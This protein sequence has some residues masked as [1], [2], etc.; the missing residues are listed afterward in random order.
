MGKGS[1]LLKNRRF[2]ITS[3]IIIFIIIF[4]GLSWIAGI[5]SFGSNKTTQ[6]N[7]ISKANGVITSVV[8]NSVYSTSGLA[9]YIGTEAGF[10]YNTNG[11]E[12][13]N[14][15]LTNTR[16]T[17]IEI[18]GISPNLK[19]FN[20]IV[21]NQNLPVILASGKTI[22]F[23]L[24]INTP[25]IP[26]NGTLMLNYNYVYKQSN[27]I[28]VTSN[29]TINNH[30]AL[31]C[32]KLSLTL[33]SPY[34]SKTG[35]CNWPGGTLNLSWSTGDSVAITINIT[36]NAGYS[37]D[38]SANNSKSF[39]LYCLSNS[40][41]VSLPPGNYSVVFS[42][43]AGGA[44]CS[45]ST[46]Y[47]EFNNNLKVSTNNVTKITSNSTNTNTSLNTQNECYLTGGNSSYY[48]T[49][50]LAQD[51]QTCKLPPSHYETLS[52]TT[53]GP[54]EIGG[55][56]IVNNGAAVYVLNNQELQEYN[57]SGNLNTYQC[58]IGASIISGSLN[59]EVPAG[60]W[61]IVLI[62]NNQQ[63]SQITFTSNVTVSY[64]SYAEESPFTIVS[65]GTN[66]NLPVNDYQWPSFQ[67]NSNA[68]ISGSFSSSSTVDGYIMDPTEFS[69]FQANGSTTS[70]YCETGS[71]T[72]A[73]IGCELG[74]GTWYFV[75]D[76]PSSYSS[77]NVNW[78]NNLTAYGLSSSPYT[79]A[80]YDE[81]F[82][83]T[84]ANDFTVLTYNVTAT[85][86]DD[87]SGIGPA[88]LLN[89]LSNT[90]Y[91]YQIGLSFNWPDGNQHYVGF[92]ADYEV[93]SPNG[94]S[95]YPT[96]G[97]GGL[98]SF[99]G[100]V[101]TGD[102]ITLTLYF[103]NGN[104]I[105][106]ATD[107]NTGAYAD[108]SYSAEGANEFVGNPTSTSINGFFTGL[109]TEWYHT[110]PWYGAGNLVTY[111]PYGTISSPAWLWV[112]EFFCYGGSANCPSSN[113]IPLYFNS[114]GSAVYPSYNFVSNAA[115]LNYFP[116]GEFTTGS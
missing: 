102:T 56:F 108:F 30:S 17:T 89:G 58:L 109:M 47:I 14:L 66:W 35:E 54:T 13:Y 63:T 85:A 43:G 60:N 46:S 20:A 114:T 50:V 80:P 6:S 83:L 31:L 74:A 104:V 73:S 65:Q 79:D 12:I 70:Y 112:D 57:S 55:T 40:Q 15:S 10:T 115:Q 23:E 22:M 18:T 2:L 88:Y 4:L 96:N 1:F 78:Q 84:F 62:N 67:L 44:I 100:Q 103:S 7:N 111:N 8:L 91:W 107:L 28:N 26:Y 53:Y 82:G 86:Q 49:T 21:L 113:R 64:I 5:F 68:L 19:G 90:G 95:I 32:N 69:T 110:F 3:M 37:Y 105:M 59:C 76:N 61:Y 42:N 24:E 9:S 92:N 87:T 29:S 101:N 27:I 41:N 106:D 52:F 93:F 71:V 25:S 33:S 116:G 48:G 34:S 38:F 77:A 51:G 81:Q 99:N 36:N 45:N 11:I 97:G 94:V 16:N 75:L 98:S 39:P 72:Y